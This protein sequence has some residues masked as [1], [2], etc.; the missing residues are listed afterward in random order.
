MQKYPVYDLSPTGTLIFEAIKGGN[1]KNLSAGEIQ[2]LMAKNRFD[3]EKE[4]QILF[5]SNGSVP[6]FSF[7]FPIVAEMY[8]GTGIAYGIG[9]GVSKEYLLA[10]NCG[11]RVPDVSILLDGQRFMGSIERGHRFEEDAE[12]TE[13]IRQIHLELAADRGWHIVNAN[14]SVVEVHER[15]WTLIREYL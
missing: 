15:I 6:Y 8:T 4:E 14:R 3:F 2:A 11:L 13:N 10:L 1:P 12:K 9:D 5:N 7:L